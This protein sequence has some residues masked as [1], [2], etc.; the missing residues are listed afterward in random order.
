[1]F[2]AICF[3]GKTL[4][5]RGWV[6]KR[7]ITVRQITVCYV[8]SD[9]VGSVCIDLCPRL[10]CRTREKLDRFAEEMHCFE[11]PSVFAH[12]QDKSFSYRYI[13]V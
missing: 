1:M 12:G 2:T 4:R 13:L 10:R 9:A 11:P 7:M 8:T 3:L 6:E 5:D